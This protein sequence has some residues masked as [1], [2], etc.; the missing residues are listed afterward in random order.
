MT[1]KERAIIMAY[2]GYAMLTGEKF[3]IFH[4]YIENLLGR[5][6][7]THELAIKE[8]ADEIHEKSK[9]DFIKLCSE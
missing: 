7:L 8:I 9:E 6:V 2:T 1:D 4:Q 3:D 5:P